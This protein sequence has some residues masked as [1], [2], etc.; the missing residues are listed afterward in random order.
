MWTEY[1]A[2]HKIKMCADEE[3]DAPDPA[4]TPGWDRGRKL[5]ALKGRGVDAAL[6]LSVSLLGVNCN[7][8]FGASA[9]LSGVSFA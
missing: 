1:R 7:C 8:R 3:G 5:T 6:I 4:C 2:K 9:C